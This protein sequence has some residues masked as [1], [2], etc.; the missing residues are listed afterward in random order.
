[1][2]PTH[3]QLHAQFMQSELACEMYCDEIVDGHGNVLYL[4]KVVSVSAPEDGGQ[5]HEYDSEK[6]PGPPG[7]VLRNAGSALGARGS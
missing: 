3:D 6:N 2:S 5:S 1:M 7:P 4:D